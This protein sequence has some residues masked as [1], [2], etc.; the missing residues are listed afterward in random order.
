MFLFVVTLREIQYYTMSFKIKYPAAHDE[1]KNHFYHGLH[2]DVQGATKIS[3]P[4]INR[5]LCYGE[6]NTP[7]KLTAL[8]TALKIIRKRQ[9]KIK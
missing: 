5:A 2:N 4:V 1:V 8:E 7:K 9:S 3:K 6:V